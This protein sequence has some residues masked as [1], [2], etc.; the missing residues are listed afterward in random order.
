MNSQIASLTRSKSVFILLFAAVVLVTLSACRAEVNVSVDEDGEGEIELIA[1]VSDT[2]MSMAQLGGED[3]FEEF[4]DTPGGELESEG[5]AGVSV[6][7]YSESG[8]TG[9]RIRAEFDPYNPALT[10]FSE[11]DSHLRRVD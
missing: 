7:P 10:T 9:V 11:G 1:A 6:E 5:L 8:Y 2:I 3:P 4:L